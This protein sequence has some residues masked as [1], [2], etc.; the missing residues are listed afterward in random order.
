MS[1]R[2]AKKDL[3][4]NSPGSSKSSG[5]GSLHPW[6]VVVG[7]SLTA[8]LGVL[9]VF[10]VRQ[11]SSSREEGSVA[12]APSAAAL[13]AAVALPDEMVWLSP[14]SYR[15]GS[16]ESADAQPVRRVEI[17]GFWIDT[18][19]VT[20]A[21]FAAFVRSTE[22]VTVAERLPDPKL[23]PGAPKELLVPGSIVFTPPAVS[24][25][26]N[27]PFSWWRYVPGAS[28]RQPEGPGSSIEDR[29]DHPVV[30]VCWEDA[31]V[32]ARWAGKRL[33]TE[34]EWEYA[35]RGGMDHKRYVWG[36]Q[37]RPDGRWQANIWQGRFPTHNTREDG[38]A[39]T[40]PVRS[41]P[42]NAFGIY[43]MAGNVWE[44]CADWY[45]PDAYAANPLRNPTGP[46]SSLDPLEPGVPK[47]VQ[48]GGSF[49]CSDLYCVR[50]EVGARGKGAPDS[51][52][53]HV[54]FR[55][56]RDGAAKDRPVR[57]GKAAARG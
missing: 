51:A 23:Y 37:F 27:Q 17:D 7:L 9:L 4:R 20:N 12:P 44:W 38:Y 33:P 45:R 56:V 47:R 10:W 2:Q 1:S 6:R 39:A 11:L 32:Y 28:W 52:A 22:Y 34:A 26:L 30:Q 54:G 42:P 21:Q 25:N 36:E 49:L 48:R 50:Y 18:T 53:N 29:T 8:A 55:C 5:R 57:S 15:Q 41:F 16:E 14:G 13:P 19:E 46:E 40:A 31:A 35:A 3:V 24:P 43:D